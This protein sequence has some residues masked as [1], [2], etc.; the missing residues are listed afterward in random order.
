MK[1]DND[2]PNALSGP[3][4]SLNP[5]GAVGP[6]A[7]AAHKTSTPTSRADQLTLSPEAQLLKAAADAVSGDL[8]V[9]SDVVAR[10]RALVADGK[11]GADATRLAE[12]L[13]DDV[14]KN[15]QANAES[16]D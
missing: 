6:S 11:I 4:D 16:H 12:A 5:T 15:Q 1:I 13:I 2:K 10:M 9:R 7:A 8:S 3:T 14:L